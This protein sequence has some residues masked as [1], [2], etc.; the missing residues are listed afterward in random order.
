MTGIGNVSGVEK[1]ELVIAGQVV[2]ELFRADEI[3]AIVRAQFGI[4]GNFVQFE[5]VP[6][7]LPPGEFSIRIRATDFAG[8]TTD[9]TITG[10]VTAS[11]EAQN[12]FL[13]DGAN[14]VGIN[15]QATG[16]AP[17]PNF[18]VEDVLAQELDTSELGPN[19]VTDVIQANLGSSTNASAGPILATSTI[20]V[21]DATDFNAGDRISVGAG[22]TTLVGNTGPNTTTITVTDGSVFSVGQGIVV[23]GEKGPFGLGFAGG[24]ESATIQSIAGNTLT[25]TT[26]LTLNHFS[27]ER[28]TGIQHARIASVAGTTITIDGTFAIEPDA[29]AAVEEE[30]KL[31][32]IVDAIF[33]FT[34]GLTV[35]GS[36]GTLTTN[37]E[38]GIFQQFIPGVGGDLLVLKQGRG[39]WFITNQE[40]FDRSAPLPGFKEGPI[41]PVTMQLDGVLFDATG[42]PPSLPATVNLDK[43]GWQQI[44]LISERSRTVERGVRGLFERGDPLFTSLVEFQKFVRFDPDTGDVEIVGGV[45]NPLF[46]GD[47]ANPG[48]TMEIGRGFYIRITEAG[49]HTP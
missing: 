42:Q 46:V 33:F 29:G 34:G 38:K 35:L 25:L 18:D 31:A 36:G 26:G 16:D 24:A 44:A 48:D 30:A 27:G 5:T 12:I 2:S 45:F 32:D 6:A 20:E 13:F 21:A 19:F 7:G 28:V 40:A 11:L 43:A 22:D 37:P 8:N 39:Y 9:T 1:V 17:A 3:P 4:T 41:I 23:T 15:L 47:I 49:T 14:L 10:D